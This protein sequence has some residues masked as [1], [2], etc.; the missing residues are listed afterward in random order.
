VITFS[1]VGLDYPFINSRIQLDQQIVP[2][3]VLGGIKE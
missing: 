2:H 1:W 3:E